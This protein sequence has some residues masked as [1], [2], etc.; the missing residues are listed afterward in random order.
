[1]PNNIVPGHLGGLLFLECHA[2]LRNCAVAALLMA[3][4]SF[5]FRQL[6]WYGSR[7]TPT[8]PSPL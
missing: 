1:M 7:H 2:H 3:V 8:Y 5:L 6:N 4:R